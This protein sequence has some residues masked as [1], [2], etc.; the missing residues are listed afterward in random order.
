M[1]TFPQMTSNV[2]PG[3]KGVLSGAS[4]PMITELG[5]LMN[6]R[7]S[8]GRSIL[9]VTFFLR[10]TSGRKTLVWIEWT[11]GPKSIIM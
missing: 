10:D 5:Q 7:S 8:L 3:R 4:I 1:Q 2:N 9:L 11:N 6:I